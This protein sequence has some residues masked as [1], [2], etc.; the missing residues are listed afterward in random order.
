M[1]LSPSLS[2]TVAIK[3]ERRCQRI[4][5]AVTTTLFESL[6]VHGIKQSNKAMVEQSHSLKAHKCRRKENGQ[7]EEEPRCQ[8]NRKGDCEW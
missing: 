5:E 8:Q 2:N 6:V 4:V 3:I 1:I 7:Y